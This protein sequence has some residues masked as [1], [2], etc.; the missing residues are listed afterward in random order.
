MGW[1]TLLKKGNFLSVAF[2]RSAA[3]PYVKLLSVML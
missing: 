2:A 3:V 1:R